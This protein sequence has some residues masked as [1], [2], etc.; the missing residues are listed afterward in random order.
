MITFEEYNLLE[1]YI[2]QENF[3]I[4]LEKNLSSKIDNDIKFGIVMA[5]HDMNAGA[6]NKSR[7]KHM[8]TP[9][10]LADALNSVKNQKY[11]NWKVYLVADK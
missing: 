6:A 7:A 10:V 1:S 5:T 11:K 2:G 4:L 8:T 9:G 3:Q